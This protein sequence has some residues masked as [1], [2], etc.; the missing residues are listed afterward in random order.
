[1]PLVLILLIVG[2]VVA[3]AISRDEEYRTTPEYAAEV[4]KREQEYLAKNI[5]Y[6]RDTDT[7]ICFARYTGQTTSLATVDCAKLDNVKVTDFT[8]N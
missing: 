1:M 8:S 7:G 4:S 2:V 6:I 5:D 3:V